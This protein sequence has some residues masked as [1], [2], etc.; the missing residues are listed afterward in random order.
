MVEKVSNTATIIDVAV[1]GEITIVDREQEKIG[2]GTLGLTGR[3][4]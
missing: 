1:P 4:A 2:N 3:L